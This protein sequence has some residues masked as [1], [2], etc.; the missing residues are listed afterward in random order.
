[1]LRLSFS[2][3]NVAQM[4]TDRQHM[5]APLRLM[6]I[7][8]LGREIRSSRIPPS[9][10]NTP[11]RQQLIRELRCKVTFARHHQPL[12]ALN[13]PTSRSHQHESQR[14]VATQTTHHDLRHLPLRATPSSLRPFDRTSESRIGHSHPT[15]PT[16]R[17]GQRVQSCDRYMH[18]RCSAGSRVGSRHHVLV[19]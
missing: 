9:K 12:S 10:Y 7:S 14:D 11:R 13:A 19:S 5:S 2:V 17:T 15:S 3:Q 18:T 4:P 6:M 8:G 16:A 1:M